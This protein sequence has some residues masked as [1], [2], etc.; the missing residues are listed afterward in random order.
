MQNLDVLREW[1]G[2]ISTIAN[3][4]K[5]S[6]ILFTAFNSGIFDL[7]ER[8]AG[9]GEIAAS[10]GWSE[11]GTAMLL[12]GLVALELLEKHSGKY[13]NTPSASACLVRN[14]EAYQGN[15]LRH[16][17]G[18]W[19]AW[20]HLEDRVRTGTCPPDE[21]RWKDQS[22]RDFILG[23]SNIAKLSAQ[24]V[25]QAVDLSGFSHVLDLAGGPGT[26]A[27]AFL[28]AH[29]R[30]RATLF[31]RPDVVEIACEQV[32]AAGLEDRFSYIAGDC[33]IDAIGQGYDLVL[34]SNLIH[35]FSDSENASLV[36]KV[37]DALA[38]GGAIIIKDFILE[39][40]R[41]GPAFSLIFALH[42]LVHTPGGNTYSY[43][44]IGRWTDQAGFEK[45]RA[46]ALTPQTRLWIARKPG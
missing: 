44:E 10:L 31:D 34:M 4:Y 13:R 5:K 14:G 42:M 16:S 21:E 40:D 15:I 25:L 26:Y 37:F 8:E 2:H 20:S 30:M 36:E 23:M 35:S 6:A 33:L 45:G 7:L 1:T 11:R 43:D 29:A 22:L 24:E 17:Q 9:A 19:D 41:S 28:N 12:D 18:S 27:I 46:L 32:A 3:A 39:N 38:P